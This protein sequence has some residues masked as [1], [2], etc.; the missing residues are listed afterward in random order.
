MPGFRAIFESGNNAVFFLKMV[1]LFARPILLRLKTIVVRN[2]RAMVA[3]CKP[4]RCLNYYWFL[5]KLCHL[6]LL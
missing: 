5:S 4:L 2:N 6:F 1:A 3:K